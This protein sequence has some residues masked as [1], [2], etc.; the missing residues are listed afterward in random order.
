MVRA[1]ASLIIWNSQKA[2][3]KCYLIK[4]SLLNLHAITSQKG[5]MGAVRQGRGS[6]QGCCSHPSDL[7]LGCWLELG[8]LLWTV[9]LLC[10]GFLMLVLIFKPAVAMFMYRIMFLVLWIIWIWKTIDLDLRISHIPYFHRFKDH[11]T[12]NDRYLLLHLLGRGG[13]S[14]VYKVRMKNWLN[15]CLQPTWR[16]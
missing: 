10:S 12:L 11:P 3:W 6:Q 2:V 9:Q 16:T 1:Y 5:R 4:F 15:Y 8:C 13:F 14:E 7:S